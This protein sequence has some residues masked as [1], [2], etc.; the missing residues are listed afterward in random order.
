[1]SS[2]DLLPDPLVLAA[3]ER[4]ERHHPHDPPGVLVGHVYA[5][6]SVAKRSA[7]AR[8]VRA[9]LDALET[10]GSLVH[11]RRHGIQTWALTSSGRRRL[12][13]ARRAGS[14]PELP[15]SPQ[16]R[17]WRDAKTGAAQEIDHFLQR[18]HDA[19]DEA[20][21][22]LDADPAAASDAWFELGE[23]LHRD[24]RNLGSATYCLREWSEPDDAHAD[25][26]DQRDPSDEQYDPDERTKRRARRAGRRNIQ[27]WDTPGPDAAALTALGRTVRRLREQQNI[28]AHELASA[29]GLQPERLA[30][31]EGGRLDPE[32]E[33]MCSLADALNVTLTKLVGSATEAE[34][35]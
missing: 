3:I 6:L 15:E 34:Q 7:S 11:S 28:S 33:L 26:D 30:A 23:R 21:L 10:A 13:R 29:A 24:C 35:Q 14:V 31:L 32:F 5:H 25:I 2:T 4:A 9:S 17:A 12:T 1:M 27:L 8:R 22:L 19:L 16:H 20:M 18:V